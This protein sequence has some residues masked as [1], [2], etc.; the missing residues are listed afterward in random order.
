MTILWHFSLAN[1]QFSSLS[2]TL[3]IARSS[4]RE[5]AQDRRH[6]WRHLRKGRASH[7]LILH[8]Q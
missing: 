3:P 8:E 5:V 1:M 6:G 4:K 2:L 7:A